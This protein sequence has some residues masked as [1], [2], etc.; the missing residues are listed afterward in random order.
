[1]V[2]SYLSSMLANGE[3]ILIETRQHWMAALRYALRPILILLAAVGL[4]IL[5]QWLVFDGWL[6]II[7]DLIGWILIILL[8]V[9][10][11]WLPI[12]L[13]RWYSRR[14]VLS[15]RRVMRMDG[16]L[17]KSSFDSSLEQINDIRTEQ[18]LLGRTLGYA[19]L[20]IYTASD[21][22]NEVYSQ[23]L[24]GLQFKKAVMEAKEAMRGGTPLEA[25]PEGFIVK[26][27]T[28]EASRG[29]DSKAEEATADAEA[30]AA[31]GTGVAASSGAAAAGV[32]A[33][34]TVIEPSGEMPGAAAIAPVVEPVAEVPPIAEPVVEA[35]QEVAEP[36]V[37]AAQEAAEPV[38]EA[39]Q[40]AAEPVVEAAQEAA[41]PVVE[42]A[43]EAAEPV[44]EAAQEA[45]EPVVEA[46]QEAAE[47]VV[48][49]AQEA[50]EP[51]VEAAQEAADEVK[52]D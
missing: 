24:D 12:D 43:Q 18:S 51:I 28:N 16:V 10:V 25:L 50:A 5:N 4:A 44:V 2:D 34:A 6:E 36:V 9:A 31:G 22:A 23:L 48:E 33:A 38:V 13:V 37:E 35:A 14:Y 45:A 3:V 47:P 7:N 40:E 41:E 19:D 1:M 30:A 27:G 49:A 32:V 17:R 8:V 42:A 52:P 20:T 15:N 29:A 46:A 11:I 26:G 21:T 39:A